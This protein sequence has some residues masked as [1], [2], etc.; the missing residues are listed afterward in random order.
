MTKIDALK[1][2]ARKAQLRADIASATEANQIM[3]DHARAQ[4]NPVE[5]AKD[6][7]DAAADKAKIAELRVELA[8]L[9]EGSDYVPVE[10]TVAP[11]V[12]AKA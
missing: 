9:S 2:N 8:C 4:E 10:I 11:A 5:R 12:A 3:T 7:R 1:L 6:L